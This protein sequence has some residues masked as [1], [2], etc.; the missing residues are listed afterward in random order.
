MTQPNPP[1]GG[2]RDYVGGS[3]FAKAKRSL[4][5]LV[6]TLALV[7]VVWSRDSLAHSRL[8]R[9]ERLL[10]NSA[11]P[12][13]LVLAATYGVLLSDDH[14]RHWRYA[15]D[16]A[17]SQSEDQSD[18]VV[19]S[20]PDGAIAVTNGGSLSVAAK[21]ACGFQEVLGET[22]SDGVPS[23]TIDQQGT[24]VAIVASSS[25]EGQTKWL[26]ESTDGGRNFRRLGAPL[27]D[28]LLYATSVRVAP[29][30]PSRIYVCGVGAD[31]S[32]ILLRSDDRGTSFEVSPLPTD[33]SAKEVPF[34]TAISPLDADAVYLRM[35][36]WTSVDDSG[37][38]LARDALLYSSDGGRSFNQ[39]LKASGKLFGFALS[40]AGDKM[41][42][43][44]GDPMLGG[45]RL[46]D[47]TALGA[48]YGG[49][50]SSELAHVFLTPV[51]CLTWSNAGIYVCASEAELGFTLG[52]S[53]PASL[54][55]TGAMSLE[56]LLA[57][58]DSN[59]VPL[60][61]SGLC[62]AHWTETCESWGREDCTRRASNDA[63][64]AERTAGSHANDADALSSCSAVP[65]R[66]ERPSHSVP[67]VLIASGILLT[68]SLGR[69]RKRRTRSAGQPSLASTEA[70]VA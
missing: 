18:T 57:L 59:L 4:V 68:P 47:P 1:K 36:A 31:R 27:T 29:S 67:F 5:W 66:P 2:A 41:L 9:A 11:S 35:D 3:A 7:V 40:P 53:D 39:L 46:T 43:G 21:Q 52:L 19:D 65:G 8:P 6:P 15:C 56:P 58:K 26:E 54:E 63:T 34:I 25:S 45:G 24:I 33:A 38:E 64:C 20:L 37:I 13:R 61:S 10:V 49:A 22:D 23:F 51:D 69:W 48:Y 44:Y 60:A 70:S 50:G 28:S 14:G 32:A 17:Y 55:S 42:V 16:E 30:D 12:S 62:D